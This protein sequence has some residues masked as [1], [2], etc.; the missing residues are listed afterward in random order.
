MEQKMNEW[1]FAN[2]TRKLNEAN[3]RIVEF[4]DIK[5]GHLELLKQKEDEIEALKDKINYLRRAYYAR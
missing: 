5:K 1:A 2:L 4:E 3:A